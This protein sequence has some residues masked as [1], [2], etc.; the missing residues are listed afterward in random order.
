MGWLIGKKSPFSI[1]D[2]TD[3]ISVE[4]QTLIEVFNYNASKLHCLRYVRQNFSDDDFS[5]ARFSFDR[6]NLFLCILSVTLQIYVGHYH[7]LHVREFFQCW[8]KV[9]FYKQ[10]DWWHYSLRALQKNLGA[11]HWFQVITFYSS[12]TTVNGW[13]TC[14]FL[15]LLFDKS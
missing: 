10:F 5:F 7:H 9:L 13:F 12:L 2:C 15:Y 3:S 8:R 1:F 4:M 14:S 6:K 11:R